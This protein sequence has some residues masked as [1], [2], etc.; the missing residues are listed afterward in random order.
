MHVQARFR[1]R[2]L[3]VAAGLALACAE[4]VAVPATAAMFVCVDAKGRTITSDRPPPECADREVRELRR[5][6]SVKRVIAPP[7]T[8]EER[9]RQAAEEQRRRQQVEEQRAQERRERA[10]LA[11]Y[12][13]ER[14]IDRAEKQA[15]ERQQASLARAT[16]RLESLRR[17]GKKLDE[18]ADFYAGRKQPEKLKAAYESNA[19]MIRDQQQVIADNAEEV[20]RIEERFQAERQHYRELK[21]RESAGKK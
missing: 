13:T 4:G 2:W 16:K 3:L 8:L 19:A 20:K 6:G 15:L 17:D 10:L 14:D 21:D 18:E 5:D 9:A 1:I 7:V 11:A 12:P